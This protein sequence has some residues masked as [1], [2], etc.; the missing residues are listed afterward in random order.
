MLYVWVCLT[1]L[2]DFGQFFI[3]D[4]SYMPLLSL[5]FGLPA[6]GAIVATPLLLI[7][8]LQSETH[9]LL[10]K[11]VMS[12]VVVMAGMI[13]TGAAGFLCLMTHFCP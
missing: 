1:I 2:L 8:T 6:F 13:L 10:R 9:S 12:L 5:A 3:F 11:V 7:E 4:C